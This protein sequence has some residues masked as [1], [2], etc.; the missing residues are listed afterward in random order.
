MSFTASCIAGL[1]NAQTSILSPQER[2]PFSFLF[3]TRLRSFKILSCT[4]LAE[5]W[6]DKFRFKG[7]AK[8][9]NFLKVLNIQKPCFYILQIETKIW[10]PAT[11]RLLPAKLFRIRYFN[12]KILKPDEKVLI[13]AKYLDCPFSLLKAVHPTRGTCS[14]CS[15]HWVAS[16]GSTS[17]ALLSTGSNF[18]THF[19]SLFR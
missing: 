7:A 9:L 12:R 10:C 15:V 18:V 2:M 8:E 5:Y 3:N 14:M 6:S 1:R 13:K 11:L 4:F 19:T 17:Y 16:I